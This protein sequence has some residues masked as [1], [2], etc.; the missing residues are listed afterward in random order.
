VNRPGASAT[1]GT[2]EV[3]KAKPDGYTILL[4]DNI[5]TVLQPRRM[6]LTYQNG[7]DFQPIIKLAEIPN[8]LVVQAD[9]RFKTLEDF[10]GA[11][12][13]KPGSLRVSTAGRFTGTDLNMLEFNKVAGI[14]T[15][16]VPVSGG[17]G[18]SVGLLLG[19][20]VEAIVAA[21]AA[22]VSQIQA[23]KLRPI[24][25]FS[26]K[27]VDLFPDLPSTHELGYKTTMR[28][29]VFISAP[30]ALDKTALNT[31][32]SSLDKAVR[33]AKFTEFA[34]RTGYQL[35]PLGPEGLAREL[36]EWGRYFAT[37]AAQLNIPPAE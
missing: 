37:L 28:V 6:K 16:T 32:H 31:L 21:P 20:H 17:T 30:K 9:S 13:A 25:V 34:K 1:I 35:D 3:Y 5:S 10:V 18:E 36:N 7:Q 23:G 2:T 14:D 19:G 27:R 15:T 26:Q 11:A 12:K 33:S 24:T 22:V 8:V 29:V 4:G